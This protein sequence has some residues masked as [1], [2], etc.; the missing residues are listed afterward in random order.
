MPSLARCECIFKQQINL[1]IVFFLLNPQPQNPMPDRIVQSWASIAER[2]Q[3]KRLGLSVLCSALNSHAQETSSSQNET[4]IIYRR[5]APLV[6]PY[7]HLPLSKMDK[8]ER[9]SM[10]SD[11]TITNSNTP[12]SVLACLSSLFPLSVY[13]QSSLQFLSP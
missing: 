7:L 12:H 8:G 11:I 2:A 4:Q 9:E 1:R 10:P 3:T 6:H 5:F 13:Q